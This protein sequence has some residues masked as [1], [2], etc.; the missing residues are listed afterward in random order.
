MLSIAFVNRKPGTAKTTC[1]VWLA[2]AY[3]EAARPVLLV[4]ADPAASTLEWADQAGGFPCRVAGLATSKLHERLPHIAR[5]DDVIVIDVPPVEVHPGIA[6]SAMRF[7]DVILIPC[8]P[9]PIEVSRTAPMLGEIDEVVAPL[10]KTAPSVAVLLNRVVHNARSTGEARD[11]LAGVGY[12]VLAAT[13]P[14]L[15][16]FAQ[17][18][19]GQVYPSTTVWP[20]VATEVTALT[21]HQ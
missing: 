6:R 17:S 3:L 7:A 21:E 1:S 2:H 9:T 14:R 8:A 10:R 12:H 16:A 18:F 5:P 15:E 20:T 11:A 19:G 13:V 4:D